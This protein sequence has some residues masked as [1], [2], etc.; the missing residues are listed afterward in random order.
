MNTWTI[1]ASGGVD[2][3]IFK[4]A[5]GAGRMEARRGPDLLAIGR[6]HPR[7]VKSV[8]G[9]HESHKK[10]STPVMTYICLVT[11]KVQQACLF[12]LS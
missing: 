11:F 5:L 12:I 8:V 7:S 1:D 4:R 10:E 2:Q 6:E 3:E 9:A